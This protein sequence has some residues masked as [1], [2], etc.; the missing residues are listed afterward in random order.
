MSG[1]VKLTQFVCPLCHK[2][3]LD[4]HDTDCDDCPH[5]KGDE[6]SQVCNSSE[7]CECRPELL[8]NSIVAENIRL[9]EDIDE[10]LA[11]KEELHEYFQE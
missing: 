11:I 6:H 5:F 8:L 3:Y 1:P 4:C 7:I 2:I 9:R 10:L